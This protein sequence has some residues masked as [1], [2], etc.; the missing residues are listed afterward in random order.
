MSEILGSEL[1]RR[2]GDTAPDELNLT[3]GGLAADLTGYSFVMTINTV[4]DPDPSID[5]GDELVSIAGV[6]N[7]GQIRFPFS[8]LN[9][10][11][12]PG[13]YWYDVQQTDPSGNTKTIRKNM[14]TFG[15]DISK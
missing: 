14:Y 4:R 11:Q 9:A 13:T 10:D 2:R 3:D 8:T 6:V 7:G 12:T 1:F 15:Q 5:L